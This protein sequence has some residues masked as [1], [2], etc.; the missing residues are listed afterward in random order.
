MNVPTLYRLVTTVGRF[1]KMVVRTYAAQ[2]RVQ[3]EGGVV[4]L[5]GNSRNEVSENIEERG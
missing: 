5:D 3:G 4:M 2:C 1:T